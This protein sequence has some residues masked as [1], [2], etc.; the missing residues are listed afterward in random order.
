MCYLVTQPHVL[1]IAIVVG[2]LQNTMV[3]LQKNSLYSTIYRIKLVLG[4]KAQADS[5]I[6]CTLSQGALLIFEKIKGFQVYIMAWKMWYIKI[7]SDGQ[8]GNVINW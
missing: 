6:K 3:C 2:L 7:L 1:L 8:L 5:Y 4:K